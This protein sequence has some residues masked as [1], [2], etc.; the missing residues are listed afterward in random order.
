MK[1][2]L[3]VRHAKSN[4]D[5]ASLSDFERP[6]NERGK[7]D[8]PMMA[9]RLKDKK[10]DINGFVSSPAK[11]AKKTAKAFMKEYGMEHEELT[12]IPSLYEASTKDFY[13]AIEQID[14]KN[15]S[16]ALFSHNPGISDFVNSLEI[17]P[18]YDMPTCAIYAL[19][20]STDSWKQFNEAE[21]RFLFF[22]YPK[23]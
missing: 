9:Q 3:L 7:E 10:I 18:V 12:L 20:I 6:L 1:T 5:N 23:K 4:W 19:E 16:V 2:L 22:D 17:F 11:R 15:N 21:K 14:D 8:A 13:D